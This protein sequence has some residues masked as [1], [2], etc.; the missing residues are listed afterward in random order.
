MDL[1][2]YGK[3]VRPSTR[4]LPDS[5]RRVTH[6]PAVLQSDVAEGSSGASKRS[7]CPFPVVPDCSPSRVVSCPLAGAVSCF[8]TASSCSSGDRRP[9]SRQKQTGAGRCCCRT[10]IDRPCAGQAG[11][12]RPVCSP[13]KE[14]YLLM[15]SRFGPLTMYCL[16][17]VRL[18]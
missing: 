4:A 14:F 7:S 6:T 2:V 18:L 13:A 8:L 17:P 1:P 15:E 9:R 16:V 12:C 3:K 11:C 10:F 5:K